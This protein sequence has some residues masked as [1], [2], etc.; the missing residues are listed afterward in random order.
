V[1]RGETK[2]VQKGFKKE[3]ENKTLNIS[4]KKKEKKKKERG[5]VRDLG[6]VIA[7]TKSQ[8]AVPTH[9][10]VPWTPT[11]ADTDDNDEASSR[12][13]RLLRTP[14]RDDDVA[15]CATRGNHEIA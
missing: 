5:R 7:T 13:K 10:P 6:L 12:E 2:N 15:L 3:S 1:L 14:A 11:P 8:K 9:H 4:R